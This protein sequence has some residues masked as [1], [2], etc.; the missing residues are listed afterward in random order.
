MDKYKGENLDEFNEIK[1]QMLT[2]SMKIN[3][4]LIKLRDMADLILKVDADILLFTEVGGKESLNNFNTHF[5]KNK[6]KVVHY[7]SNSERGIDI[8]A[9]VKPALKFKSRFHGEKAFAR[10]VLEIT[11]IINNTSICFLHTHLK[12]KLNLRG[13]DFEGRSQRQK[14]VNA[15]T[16]IIQQ[17]RKKDKVKE[18]QVLVTGDLN[19]IIYQDQT[20]PELMSFATNLGLKDA[21][22]HLKFPFFDRWSYLY[23]N[24]QG[25]GIFMQLDYCLMS[26]EIAKSLTVETKILNFEG[27]SRTVF[28]KNIK[29]KFLHP[30][31][32]YPVQIV[33]DCNKIP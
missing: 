25:E 12:S 15:L 1:W 30:S 21:F 31:D 33:L 26:K 8:A 32:H 11:T 20:E 3:K 9:L 18:T 10:G 4:P 28:P 6:F 22:E 13:K 7:K 27:D 16:K 19:G 24:K 23:Y 17:K 14:E 5:L 29:E 2:T